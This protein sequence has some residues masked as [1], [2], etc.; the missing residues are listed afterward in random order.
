MDVCLFDLVFWVS[1][2]K[3]P[4]VELLGP[5]LIASVLKCILSGIS[6]ATPP[7]FV[8]FHFHEIPFPIPFSLCI[9]QSEVSVL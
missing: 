2:D 3:Y 8:C 5:S 1:L 7:F 9:F 4:E 6:I